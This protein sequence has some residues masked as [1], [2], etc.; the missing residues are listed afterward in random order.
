[1]NSDNDTI[2]LNEL[3][4]NINNIVKSTNKNE[5]IKNYNKYHSKIKQVDEILYN[6]KN[7][8]DTNYDLQY[9]FD[10][11]KEFDLLLENKDITII[12]FKKLIELVDLIELK[13]K[14]TN[15]IVKEDC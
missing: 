5:F 8:F 9:L 13:I 15:L 4:D 10:M 1:M 6:Y 3:V 14:S 11:L 12:Q 2:Y 7:E